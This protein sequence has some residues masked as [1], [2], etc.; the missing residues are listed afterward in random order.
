MMHG[1]TK[2]NCNALFQFTDEDTDAANGKMWFIRGYSWK[3][4]T[5]EP[6]ILQIEHI[7][8]SETDGTPYGCLDLNVGQVDSM[9]IFFTMLLTVD[10]N[11]HRL[12]YYLS[13]YVDFSSA[14]SR[15]ALRG[16]GCIL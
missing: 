11:I 3:V 13:I 9:Y 1:H 16:S 10:T 15:H 12:R 7:N 6:I 2:L 8:S 14:S 4:N 5:Q